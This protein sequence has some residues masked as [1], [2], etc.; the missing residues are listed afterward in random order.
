MGE[1]G[2]PVATVVKTNVSGLIS[3]RTAFNPFEAIRRLRRLLHDRPYEFRYTLRIIP[4]E[5]VVGTDLDEIQHAAIGLASKIEKDETFRVTVEKRF[6][7]LHRQDIV[8]VVAAKV[9][10]KVDLHRPDK[11]LLV[12]IVGELA[13]VS[14]IRARDIISV[15]REKLL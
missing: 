7:E 1:I 8:E 12:E 11:I 13:G 6:T 14:V 3:A 4:I 10:R 15:M 5:R 9:E 2:D